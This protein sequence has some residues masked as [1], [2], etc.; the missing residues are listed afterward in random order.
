MRIERPASGYCGEH[1]QVYLINFY[2][3]FMFRTFSNIMYFVYFLHFQRTVECLLEK[4]VDNL[5]CQSINWEST[6]LHL[7]L[8]FQWKIRGLVCPLV[9]LFLQTCLNIDFFK[10]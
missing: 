1:R 9:Y 3:I 4:G 8:L 2:F 5:V 6:A 7:A 10:H